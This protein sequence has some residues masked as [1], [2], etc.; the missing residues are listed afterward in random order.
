MISPGPSPTPRCRSRVCPRSSPVMRELLRELQLE[1]TILGRN[2]DGSAHALLP[3]YPL[4]TGGGICAGVMPHYNGAWRPHSESVQRIEPRRCR[5][6]H[7]CTESIFVS[8]IYS[9]LLQGVASPLFAYVEVPVSRCTSKGKEEPGEAGIDCP[10]VCVT[11]ACG[12]VRRLRDVRHRSNDV[13]QVFSI[14][15]RNP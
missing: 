3:F 6:R 10:R 14:D 9:A 7:L 1:G 5:V 13:R 4:D 11:S 8:E 12:Y 15:C 2:G